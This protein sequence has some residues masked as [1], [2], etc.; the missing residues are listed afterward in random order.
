MQ[1]QTMQNCKQSSRHQ[2]LQVFLPLFI[3]TKK[4]IKYEKMRMLQNF[5]IST[6]TVATAQILRLRNS[7]T[8][9]SY[10]S[11]GLAVEGLFSTLQGH[12]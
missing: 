2:C 6:S 1:L 5:A 11:R 12:E 7:K 4:V 10:C 9:Q 8:R 3:F